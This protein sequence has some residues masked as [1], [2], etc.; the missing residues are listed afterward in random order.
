M[1]IMAMA[2]LL[3]VSITAQAESIP[4]SKI[5]SA[6]IDWKGITLKGEDAV[7]RI[8]HDCSLP[9]EKD[10]IIG[11]QQ[12][13]PSRYIRPGSKIRVTVDGSRYV[14]DIQKIKVL[15]V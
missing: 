8:T 2:L 10:S 5:G 3:A 13:R 14:C 11:V 12:V 15:T 1:K 9:I 4:T 7:W 6:R